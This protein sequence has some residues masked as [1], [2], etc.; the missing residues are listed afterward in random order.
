M[1]ICFHFISYNIWFFD[2]G[3]SWFFDFIRR[4]KSSKIICGNSGTI[5]V[6]T[7]T[8]MNADDATKDTISK[9]TLEAKSTVE[10]S[11]NT[12][13]KTKTLDS[14]DVTCV[15]VGK[16]VNLIVCI[17]KLEINSNGGTSEQ[18]NP[19]LTRKML[20]LLVSAIL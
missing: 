9:R 2:F 6:T 16:T 20:T 19:I 7:T 15:L 4:V 18:L 14:L 11:S 12:F 17:D 8:T 5:K 3:R 13:I 10:T 1:L